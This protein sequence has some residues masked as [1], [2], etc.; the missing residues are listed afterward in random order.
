MA[1]LVGLGVSTITVEYDAVVTSISGLKASVQKVV[2]AELEFT[3]APTASS[4]SS[5]QYYNDLLQ[6]TGGKSIRF[7]IESDETVESIRE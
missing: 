2:H 6:A 4:N 5:K 1:Q 3:L 7:T